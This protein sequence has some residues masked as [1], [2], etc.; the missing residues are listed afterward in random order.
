MYHNSVDI[1]LMPT[2]PGIIE[3][4][5]HLAKPYGPSFFEQVLHNRAAVY[6]G[7]LRALHG[8]EHVPL[9]A[10]LHSRML[11]GDRGMTN[12]NVTFCSRADQD[13]IMNEGDLP[14]EAI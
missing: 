6:K 4:K 7:T 1:V 5:L 11:T 12:D 10:P 9:F 14:G 8:T 3:D 2:R 13:V